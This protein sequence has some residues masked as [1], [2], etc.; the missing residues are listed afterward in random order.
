M[1][2]GHMF[3]NSGVAKLEENYLNSQITAIENP[4]KSPSWLGQSISLQ[5][6][7][8]LDNWMQLSDLQSLLFRS[9]AKRDGGG[10][11]LYL[12]K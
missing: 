7:H 11:M 3:L 12:F 10:S 8:G 1:K 9:T 6:K 4:G 5:T 2:V